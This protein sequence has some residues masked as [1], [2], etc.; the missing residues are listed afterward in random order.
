MTNKPTCR[1]GTSED[2]ESSLAAFSHPIHTNG[3]HASAKIPDSVRELISLETGELSHRHKLSTCAVVSFHIN[4]E[5]NSRWAE[6]WNAYNNGACTYKSTECR[7]E[8]NL[9]VKSSCIEQQL[10]EHPCNPS[11]IFNKSKLPWIG[12]VGLST[13]FNVVVMKGVVVT[14]VGD[15]PGEVPKT[16]M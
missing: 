16:G 1:N 14:T 5:V 9:Q 4:G 2:D 15:G 6:R 7:Q 3:V 10:P 12:G 8:L 11:S 13:S